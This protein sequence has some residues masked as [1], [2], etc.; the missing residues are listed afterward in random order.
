MTCGSDS[1]YVTFSRKPWYVHEMNTTGHRWRFRRLHTFPSYPNTC[2]QRV[3]QTTG[4][5][6]K[7][8]RGWLRRTAPTRDSKAFPWHRGDSNRPHN[9]RT[10]LLV[11]RKVSHIQSAVDFDDWREH[12]EHVTP[13]RHKVRGHVTSWRHDRLGGDQIA[14]AAVGAA[15]IKNIQQ[16]STRDRSSLL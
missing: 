8:S 5:Y 10:S 2:T 4:Q 9:N 15:F 3:V 14:E 12:P 11:E 7:D 6:P 1:L 13:W 16:K